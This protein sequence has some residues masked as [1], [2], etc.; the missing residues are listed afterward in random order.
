MIYAL[1]PTHIVRVITLLVMI[2]AWITLFR[3][4]PAEAHDFLRQRGIIIGLVNAIVFLLTFR[5]IFLILYRLT[6]ASHWWFPLL[7][8][9]WTGELRSNWP[10]IEAMMLAAKG[11]RPKFDVLSDELPG[12]S[13]RVTTLEAT[14]RCSL[15]YVQIDICIPG[16]RRTSQTIFARPEWRRPFPPQLAYMYDQADH[17]SVA[18]TDAPRHR[19]AA[20]LDYD[21]S[22]G[23]L[24]GEYWTNRQAT[25]GL[26]TAGSLILKRA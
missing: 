6:W 15:F 11:A 25:K 13:E 24:R 5:P 12:S 20:V 18:V 19:G 9:R 14:I 26:N 2:A 7:D 16:T 3:S 1:S 8:G 4:S 21:Q 23:E 22:T 17:G 10:R